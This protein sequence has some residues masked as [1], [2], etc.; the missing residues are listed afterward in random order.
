MSKQQMPVTKHFIEHPR[1]GR[2]VE[3]KPRTVGNARDVPKKKKA[4][5]NSTGGPFVPGKEIS[6]GRE[7][8][9]LHR[10]VN[11]RHLHR[12]V[13]FHHLHCYVNFH[14]RRCRDFHRH[15]YSCLHLRRY[16]R[17]WA[18]SRSAKAPDSYGWARNKFAASNTSPRTADCKSAAANSRGCCWRM[19]R[20]R[21]SVAAV[22]MNAR[23]WK[24][25]GGCC[26]SLA[27]RA[28]TPGH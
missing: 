25:L 12:Y 21:Q 22:R 11:F 1:A 10:R 24:S 9:S 3:D 23:C 6:G 19:G 18:R 4:R 13:N 15:H 2:V 8:L 26:C 5:P 28:E 17:G 16:S 14:H 7:S 27:S 20:F